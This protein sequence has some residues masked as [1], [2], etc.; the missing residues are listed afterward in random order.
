MLIAS[1]KTPKKPGMTVAVVLPNCRQS[2]ANY[3]VF[4]LLDLIR[5]SMYNI[6]IDGIV[7]KYLVEIKNSFEA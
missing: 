7:E 2:A 1:F 5:T 3:V 6:H 4:L